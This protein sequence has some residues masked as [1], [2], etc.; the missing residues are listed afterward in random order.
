MSQVEIVQ[1]KPM[2]RS[3]TFWLNIISTLI[4]VVGVLNEIHEATL[5][6]GD[7]IEIPVWV[8]RY[9]LLIN[10]ILNIILRRLTDSPARF[11]RQP[12]LVVKESK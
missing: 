10:S 3:R 5:L 11:V 8:T 7:I 6:F 12:T 1:A 4:A 2:S 9:I